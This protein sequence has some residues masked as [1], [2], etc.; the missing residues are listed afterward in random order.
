MLFNGSKPE[1]TG[2]CAEYQEAWCPCA[3]ST[4]RGQQ[5]FQQ[6]SGAAEQPPSADTP[7]RESI[8]WWWT[9]NKDG[10]F[11]LAILNQLRLTTCCV[12]CQSLARLAVPVRFLGCT[13]TF[14]ICTLNS[15]LM[16]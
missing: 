16:S 1:A 2:N 4:P 13:R 14:M 11:S 5:G 8:R 6:G 7:Q 10:R 12:Q 9:L 15:C 3:G